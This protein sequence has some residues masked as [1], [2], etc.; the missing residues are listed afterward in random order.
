MSVRGEDGLKVILER[1]GIDEMWSLIQREYIQDQPQRARW[2]G[3]LALREVSGWTNEMIAQAFGQD[4]G[5]VC[6]V[7]SQLRAELQEQFEV[8]AGYWK[9]GARR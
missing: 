7:L 1:D 2:L 5:Y 3:M 4:R 6:R 9:R 8:P